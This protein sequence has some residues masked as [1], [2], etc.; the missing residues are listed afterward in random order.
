MQFTKEEKENLL[1]CVR[2]VRENHEHYVDS[3]FETNGEEVIEEATT[4]H[5]ELL[6][7]EIKLIVAIGNPEAV[8]DV[9]NLKKELLEKVEAYSY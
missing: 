4:K 5:M 2:M 9:L 8:K 6:D 3:A 1:E 7:L